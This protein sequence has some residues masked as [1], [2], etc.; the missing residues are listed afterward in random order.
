[1]ALKHVALLHAVTFEL[2]EENGGYDAMVAK[3]PFLEETRSSGNDENLKSL[4]KTKLESAIELLKVLYISITHS[5]S[6]IGQY[7]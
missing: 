6:S 1:M 3:Y 4:F 2:I 5:G 7:F